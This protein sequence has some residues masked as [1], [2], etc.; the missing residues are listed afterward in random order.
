MSERDES[1][2]RLQEIEESIRFMQ[3]RLD[4]GQGNMTMAMCRLSLNMSKDLMA[5]AVA[6]EKDRK[7]LKLAR[8]LMAQH[9][10]DNGPCSDAPDCDVDEYVPCE[11]EHC[12]YCAMCVSE[13]GHD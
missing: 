5:M 8:A 4:Q 10:M 2:V 7:S 6:S 9:M 1:Q 12:S 13:F 3:Q 11:D